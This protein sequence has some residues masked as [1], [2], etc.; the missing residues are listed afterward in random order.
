[1]LDDNT[2]N[3]IDKLQ[4]TRKDFDSVLMNVDKMF[5]NTMAV[6]SEIDKINEIR[7]KIQMVTENLSALSEENAAASE[8]TTASANMVVQ[9]MDQ[10]NDATQ[11]ISALAAR[12]TD[13]ISYFRD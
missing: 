11:E 8:E 3:Q 5:E 4:D 13:I 2:K 9:S 1:M 10:L 12:L 7:K 6:Q